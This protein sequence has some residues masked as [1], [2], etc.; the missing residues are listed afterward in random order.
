MD[1]FV[2]MI[3]DR[4][5]ELFERVAVGCVRMN[6]SRVWNRQDKFIIAQLFECPAFR[7]S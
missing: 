4:G 2:R 3:E 1:G 7:I 5:E 6:V